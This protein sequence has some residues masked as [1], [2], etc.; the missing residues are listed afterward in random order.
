MGPRRAARRKYFQAKDRLKNAD[1]ALRA[2]T[3]TAAKWHELKR[4]NDAARDTYAT[5]EKEIEQMSAEQRKVGRIRRVYPNVRRKAELDHTIA[6]LGEVTELPEDTLHVLRTAERDDG[7]AAVRVETLTDQLEAAQRERA[8]LVYDEALILHGHD[9]EQLHERRIKVRDGRADL[10]KRR[11][12]LAGAEA[13]LRRL[14]A[15]LEW[16]GTDVEQFIGRIPA[17]A[18]V[19]TVRTFLNRRV[20]AWKRSRMRK[21]PPR[22]RRPRQPSFCGSRRHWERWP[23]CR[24]SRQ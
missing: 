22:R 17:R 1:D 11:A 24:S 6:D 15:E 19:T 4:V 18:K 13:D 10:P 9:I 20:S 23:T 8:E 5:L 21:L 7:N 14:A 2:Q 12:E 3:V 16:N